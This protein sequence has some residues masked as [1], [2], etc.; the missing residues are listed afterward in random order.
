M[1][2]GGPAFPGFQYTEGYGTVRHVYGPDG[3]HHIEIHDPGMTLR[4]RFAGQATEE[5]I[6]AHVER[7]ENGVCVISLG[8]RERAKYAYADAMIAAREKGTN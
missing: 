2:D 5:D 7:D 4:D 6:S 3:Q 8:S 1:K